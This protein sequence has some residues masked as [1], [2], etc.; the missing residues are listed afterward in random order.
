[1]SEVKFSHKGS[2]YYSH[3]R[4]ADSAACILIPGD[5]TDVTRSATEELK[6]ACARAWKKHGFEVKK[7]AKMWPD[8]PNDPEVERR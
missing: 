1:M 4:V 6:G 7:W 3:N 5:L 2:I 8:G